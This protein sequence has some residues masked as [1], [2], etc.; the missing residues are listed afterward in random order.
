MIK[1]FFLVIFL[2]VLLST[3][4][5]SQ[6]VKPPSSIVRKGDL[7]AHILTSVS[8]PKNRALF[9]TSGLVVSPTIQDSS[10]R[11]GYVLGNTKAQAINIFQ[12]IEKIL[13]A[14]NLTLKDVVFI[15]A[16]VAP[17]KILGKTDF[18]GWNEAYSTF[19]N[20]SSN[21]VKVGRATVGV[22]CLVN[23]DW[24]IEIEVTAVYP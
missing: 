16:F 23:A 4:T 6:E 20:T 2:E 24:L 12:Q 8:I 7:N 3:F 9:L 21:P 22:Q 19:F 1:S 5:F 10:Q 13:A 11:N 18:K 15:R 17:D 14:E